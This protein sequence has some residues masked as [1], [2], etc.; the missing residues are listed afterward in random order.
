MIFHAYATNIRNILLIYQTS[1]SMYYALARNKHLC[2]IWEGF[3][4]QLQN[5]KY[6]L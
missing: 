5:G 6:K 4:G 3:I 2:I 1:C